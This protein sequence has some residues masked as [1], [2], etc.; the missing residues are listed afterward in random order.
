MLPSPS[1]IVPPEYGPESTLRYLDRVLEESA[2]YRS[3]LDR[4]G[5]RLERMRGSAADGLVERVNRL[6][7]GCLPVHTSTEAALFALREY[8][9]SVLEIHAGARRAER[10][11]ESSATAI[12]A[13]SAQIGEIARELGLPEDF[14]WDAPPSPVMP[15]PV[16]PERLLI[17]GALVEAHRERW[18]VAARRW[19]EALDDARAARRNWLQLV[20][21][22]RERERMLMSRLESTEVGRLAW[23]AESG[24]AGGIARAV[25]CAFTPDRPWE[26]PDLQ[27]LIGGGL[28]AAEATAA[29]N[30]LIASD[31]DIGRLIRRY[32]FELAD[33]DGIPFWVQDR[34]SRLALNLALESD[35]HLID[36]YRRM[37]FAPGARSMSEFRTDLSVLRSALQQADRVSDVAQL[38]GFGSRDGVVTAAISFGD[39]DTA[40]TVGVFVSGMRSKCAADR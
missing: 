15:A 8:A 31:A 21:E 3:C 26:P 2:E 13:A 16:L 36:A 17:G 19:G 37:G 23:A 6:D 12:R 32:C 34:A 28:T 29:W 5:S 10:T 9:G 22:R 24:G 30:R 20:A 39:L 7:S 14:A 11:V 1:P 35:A 4:V 40:D 38:V 33:V 18:A 25:E 27:L